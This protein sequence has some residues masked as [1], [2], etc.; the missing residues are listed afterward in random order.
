MASKEEIA[1]YTYWMK[2]FDLVNSCLTPTRVTNSILGCKRSGMSAQDIA[3]A[4]E[5]VVEDVEH[6]IAVLEEGNKILSEANRQIE[7]WVEENGPSP[8]LEGY[9]EVTYF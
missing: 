2:G 9:D 6:D 8:L 4:F 1:I 3:A 5:V 7:K